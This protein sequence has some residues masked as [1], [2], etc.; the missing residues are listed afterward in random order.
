M[1]EPVRSSTANASATPTMPSPSSEIAWPVNSRP[2]LPLAQG[3]E[4]VGDA[5]GQPGDGHS[6]VSGSSRMR[7]IGEGSSQR[8]PCI[9]P[10]V[11]IQSVFRTPICGAEKPARQ[12]AERP[13]AVVDEHVRAGD[14]R[15]QP[16]RNDCGP[17]RAA[18]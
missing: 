13:H 10:T 4:R 16:V 14:A 9:A 6:L 7:M 3:A 12:R 11:A 8:T 15:A 18:A 1:T 17:D 2:E 5:H